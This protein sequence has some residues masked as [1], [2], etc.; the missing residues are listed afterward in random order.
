LSNFSGSAPKASFYLFRTEVDAIEGQTEEILLSQ[1]LEAAYDSGV[2]VASISLGYTE[3][4]DDGTNNHTYAELDGKTTIAAKAVNIAASKGMIVCV[5]AGNEGNKTWKY[6]G[7]PADADSA[8]TIGAVDA[9]GDT[10]S[11]TSYQF[12]NTTKV[13]PN[14]VAMGTATQYLNSANTISSGNGTSYSTPV[15]AGLTACLWQAFPEKTNWEIKTAIEQ[16]AH[17]YPNTDNKRLGYGI[18]DFE[19]AYK[20]LAEM[21]KIDYNIDNEIKVFPTIFSDKINIS[22]NNNIKEINIYTTTGRL[23][24][25]LAVDEQKFKTIVLDNLESNVYLLQIITE[26]NTI[27]KKV[28]KQ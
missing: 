5:S 16:S 6:L 7:T 11:F 9:N 20:S 1:A 15:I 25:R 23:I 19:K 24:D 3:G 10:S 4:F 22:S 27:T 2:H 12:E 26:Q 21:T 13:K 28:I 14:V 8:F 18:P 17:L